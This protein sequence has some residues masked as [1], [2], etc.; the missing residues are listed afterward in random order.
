MDLV[1]C[2][3]VVAHD[4]VVFFLR[5]WSIVLVQRL[6]I[7]YFVRIFPILCLL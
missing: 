5:L 4:A 2:L 6:W 1:S 7:S 3:I